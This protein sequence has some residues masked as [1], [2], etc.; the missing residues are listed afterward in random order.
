[1]NLKENK[2]QH[3]VTCHEC[4]N[5]IRPG[6]IYYQLPFSDRYGNKWNFCI[7]CAKEYLENAIKD[8][9]TILIS[10]G[11]ILPIYEE[12]NKI[13]CNKCKDKYKHVVGECYPLDYGC[14]PKL[15]VK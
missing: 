2:S 9:K 8:S 15:M 12:E 5:W 7:K 4:R 1:M 13:I 14:R 3:G 11:K 6:L 10:I